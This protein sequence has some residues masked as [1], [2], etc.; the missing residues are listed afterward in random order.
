MMD[1]RELI[2]QQLRVVLGTMPGFSPAQV[3]RNRGEFDDKHTKLPIA[4]L[5]DGSERKLSEARS[6]RETGMLPAI[7][8][9][10]PQIFTIIEPKLL[11]KADDYGPELSGIRMNLLKA[12][13]QD[14]ALRSLLGSNGGID[15]QGADTDMQTGRSME[16]QIQ[17]NFGFRYVFNPSD[18]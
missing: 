1:K 6:G 8:L 10:S 9:L 3:Y 16:G 7:F 2:L 15:Y 11:E 12:I 13:S 14:S 4:I 5:L 18:L 17:F